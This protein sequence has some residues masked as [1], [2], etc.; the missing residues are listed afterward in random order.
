MEM[1]V[2]NPRDIANSTG[3]IRP[4][5]TG[6]VPFKAVSVLGK[7]ISDG[8]YQT[9]FIKV[10]AIFIVIHYLINFIFNERGI[11]LRITQHSNNSFVLF[12]L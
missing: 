7:K 4:L 9:L 6:Q 5:G 11:K 3:T 2:L 12:L 10:G 8:R 1:T